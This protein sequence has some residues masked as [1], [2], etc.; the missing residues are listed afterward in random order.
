MKVCDRICAVPLLSQ[1]LEDGKRIKMIAVSSHLDNS[2]TP[3]KV[4]SV[5]SLFNFLNALGESTDCDAI[6]EGED[7][8]ID[9]LDETEIAGEVRQGFEIPKYDPTIHHAIHS[10]GYMCID[11]FTYKNFSEGIA[12]MITIDDVEAKMVVVVPDLINATDAGQYTINISQYEKDF[13]TVR[14]ASNH[15][16]IEATLNLGYHIATSTNSSDGTPRSTSKKPRMARARCFYNT[17]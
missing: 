9:I 10:R 16:P 17:N 13:Q 11:Y 3:E 2:S 4:N 14:S 1:P 8:N 12:P 15:D 5:K 7:F 6:I